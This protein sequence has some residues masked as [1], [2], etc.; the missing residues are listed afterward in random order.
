MIGKKV[1]FPGPNSYNRHHSLE[2]N[3]KAKSFGVS[4]KAYRKVWLLD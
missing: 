4:Y 1:E 3:R 2:N